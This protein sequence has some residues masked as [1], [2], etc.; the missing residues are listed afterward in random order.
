[1]VSYSSDKSSTSPKSVWTKAQR[2]LF[3][4]QIMPLIAEN[5]GQP[6]TAYP[7]SLYVATTPEEQ[8]YLSRSTSIADA[9]ASSRANMGRPAYEINP[10]TTE[11][12]YQQAIKAPTMREWEQTVEPAIREAYTGPGYYGSARA[13]ATRKAAED[14]EFNLAAQRAE[15]YYADEQSRRAALENAATRDAQ[16]GPVAAQTEATVLGSAGEYS[17]MI[18]QEEITADLQRWLMGEEVDGQQAEQYSPW[19]QLAFSALGLQGVQLA[20]SSS[21]TTA[22]ISYSKT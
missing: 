20:G 11:Q 12:Y 17:R 6:A 1:M 8:T 19:L 14:M 5:F 16:F 3:K 18:Q 15:L 22:A 2:G 9:I 10:E 7:R 21:G 4:N 13:D